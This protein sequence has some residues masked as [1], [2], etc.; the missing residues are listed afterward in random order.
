[1]RAKAV[2]IMNIVNLR[3]Y[4]QKLATFSHYC[5]TPTSSLSLFVQCKTN[6]VSA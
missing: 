1:M 2:K 6:H 3:K 4:W 5:F